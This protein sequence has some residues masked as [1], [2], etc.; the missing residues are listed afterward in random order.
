MQSWCSS[1]YVC[2]QLLDH[3]DS[4]VLHL[5]RVFFFFKNAFGCFQFQDDICFNQIQL[6]PLT[7]SIVTI[8]WICASWY[9]FLIKILD[10]SF[11]ISHR[12]LQFKNVA[13]YVHAYICIQQLIEILWQPIW[14]K[15][16]EISH[17]ILTQ[18]SALLF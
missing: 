8:S 10:K 7:S 5:V 11:W 9:F 17:R 15:I 18:S 3:S 6:N 4:D 2:H 14:I 12:W 16:M 1:F 13:T